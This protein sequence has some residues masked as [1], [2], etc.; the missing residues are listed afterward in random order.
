MLILLR[1]S[2]FTPMEHSSLSGGYTDSSMPTS[3]PLPS[4]PLRLRFLPA[5]PLSADGS[6]TPK[7]V[8][9]TPASFLVV[10]PVDV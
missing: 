10:P 5:C 8:S 9:D 7:P 1:S 2:D 3:F 6:I 4:D